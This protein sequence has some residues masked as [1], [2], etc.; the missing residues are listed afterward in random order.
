[1]EKMKQP[2]AMKVKL[3]QVHKK[4][5]VWMEVAGVTLL[6]LLTRFYRA[7]DPDIVCWDET[8]FGKFASFYLRGENYFDVHPPLGGY[9]NKFLKNQQ[10]SYIIYCAIFNNVNL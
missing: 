7:C 2:Q 8:H 6:A 3:L 5:D 9:L 4:Y 10:T 1:M